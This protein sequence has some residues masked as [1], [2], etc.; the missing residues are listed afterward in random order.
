MNVALQNR[1]IDFL[2]EV[3]EF[4]DNYSD[5]E[6][7]GDPST[8]RPNRAMRMQIEAQQLRERIERNTK[9]NWLLPD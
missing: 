3:E 9:N 1:L 4:C 8:F 2:V 5:A 6:V 7:V